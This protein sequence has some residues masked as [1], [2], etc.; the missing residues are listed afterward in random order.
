MNT[1]KDTEFLAEAQKSKLDIEPIT[2]EEAERI[3]RSLFKLE[4]AIVSRLKEILG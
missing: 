1:M 2:G 4:P 3:V